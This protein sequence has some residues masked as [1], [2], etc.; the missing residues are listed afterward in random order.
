MGSARV[1]GLAIATRIAFPTGGVIFVICSVID[2][3]LIL[4]D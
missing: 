3:Q 1:A 4:L 2:N